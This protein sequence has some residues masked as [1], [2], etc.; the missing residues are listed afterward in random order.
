[1]GA[2]PVVDGQLGDAKAAVVGEHRDEAV[3]LAVEGEPADDLGAI[4]LEPAV[5]VV[6]PEPGDAAGD[7][8]EDPREQSPPQRV[9]AVR[10]P[11]GDEVEALVELGQQARDLGGVVLEV[12]VDR[13]DGLALRLGE[14]GGERGRLAEVAAQAHDPGVR[15]PRVEPRQGGE[16]A[17]RRAVV[18]E[19]RLPGLPGRLE[20]RLEL[21]VE[22][23]D[24][25]FLVVDRDDDRDHGREPSRGPTAEAAVARVAV[26]VARVA[27]AVP[28][29]GA[30]PAVA[31]AEVAAVV[32]EAAVAAAVVAEAVRRWW[33]RRWRRRRRWR[34][35]R[36]VGGRG[37]LAERRARQR[38]RCRLVVRRDESERD[39]D[40]HEDRQRDQCHQP[41]RI[42]RRRRRLHHLRHCGRPLPRLSAPPR[43]R[44]ARRAL[45][46][47]PGAASGSLASELSATAASAAGASGRSGGQRR[48][49][50]LELAAKD[51][52]GARRLE[53]EPPRQHPVEDDSE[54]VD[55]ARGRHRLALRL[56]RGHVRGGPH[57]RPRIREGVRAGHPRDA[58]VGDL[59]AA[60]LVEDDV[61]RLQVA[62]DQPSV[63]RV[64]EPGRDLGRDPLALG[65]VQRLPRGETIFQRAAGKMLEDHVPPAVRASVV[66]EPA[67]VRMGERRDRLGLA[68]EA[69]RIGVRSEQLQRDPPVELGVVRQ[70]DLRHAARAEL[71]L[72]TVSAAD[73]LAHFASSL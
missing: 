27:A 45:L 20:R 57:Q 7:G 60:L 67:D 35:G 23:G 32:A 12:A 24:A 64:R 72:E 61:R 13:D 62:V 38:R 39:A 28:V 73:R 8:V 46:R 2:R 21:L 70:P 33:W 26:L 47:R 1:M 9:A 58:E 42:R 43:R 19:D 51:L 71:L 29:V 49:R 40:E 41:G 25:P 18:D 56:L 37:R 5:H 11:A 68:L 44:A 66:E 30:A 16:R 63:V 55:V 22:Q 17:V 15:R 50:F 36:C 3:E 53:R 54:G 65:V 52:D 48:R 6:Q 10:L 34:R 59:R 14:A 69:L 31:A 4:G